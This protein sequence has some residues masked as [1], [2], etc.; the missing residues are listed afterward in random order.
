MRSDA[1]AVVKVLIE[2][3]YGNIDTIES[4]IVL[5]QQEDALVVP[6]LLSIQTVL[7]ELLRVAEQESVALEESDSKPQ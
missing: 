4:Q 5:N 2:Q 3:L 6:P 1:Q 7:R